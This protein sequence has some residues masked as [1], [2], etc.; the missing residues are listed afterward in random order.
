[1]LII[2]VTR[3]SRM[4]E[5][6]KSEVSLVNL[7]KIK[8]KLKKERPTDQPEIPFYVSMFA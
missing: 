6:C 5:D 2:P 4:Q 1:M 8:Y 7:V 3:E